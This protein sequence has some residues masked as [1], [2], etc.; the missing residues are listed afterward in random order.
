MSD[1]VLGPGV[2]MMKGGKTYTIS[3]F[4]ELTVTLEND[5]VK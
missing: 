1:P 2:I 4:G 3:A 5:V